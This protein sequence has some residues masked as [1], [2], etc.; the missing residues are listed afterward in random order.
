MKGQYSKNLYGLMSIPTIAEHIGETDI[1]TYNILYGA[2]D[3]IFCVLLR[4][5]TVEEL[6]AMDEDLQ[7]K[8]K[9][10]HPIAEMQK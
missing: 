8:H 2:M 7:R 1:K 4:K 5:F 6:Y 9:T 3:K 10:I